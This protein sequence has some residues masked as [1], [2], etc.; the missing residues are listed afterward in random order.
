[1]NSLHDFSS[2]LSIMF[3]RHDSLSKSN[4][5]HVSL[6]VS[7][8]V[9]LYVFLYV[10]LYVF[11]Y[12]SLS[13]DL[14]VF[15]SWLS[16]KKIMQKSENFLY[17]TLLTSSLNSWR[18]KSSWLSSQLSRVMLSWKYAQ[19]NLN[20]IKNISNSTLNQ[21]EFKMSTQNSIQ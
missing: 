17:L 1:M 12:D 3:F 8:Y 6:H 20:W 2:W 9:F 15:S 4:D 13:N 14:H 18:V 10:S 21:V 5:L 16:I 7:L 19:L 11:L